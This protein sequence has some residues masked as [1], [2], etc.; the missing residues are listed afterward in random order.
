MIVTADPRGDYNA[1]SQILKYAALAKE[2]TVPRVVS[3]TS[4]I[5]PNTSATMAPHRTPSA[6]LAASTTT[7]HHHPAIESQAHIIARLT[8]ELA[9][10]RAALHDSECERQ[11][12]ES[13][14][15]AAETR[16]ERLEAEIREECWSSFEARLAQERARWRAAWEVER[17]E[18]EGFIDEKVG[19][20]VRGMAAVNVDLSGGGA[21]ASG[22][23]AEEA[24]EPRRLQQ[25]VA[26]LEREND[27]LKM[28][29]TLR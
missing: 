21:R 27:V 14:W 25:R 5:L 10:A 4:S 8:A 22:R 9:Q 15:A 23:S 17:E 1:T 13:S 28:K 2:T 12:L 29:S 19:A 11:S 24:D 20:L 3:V 18:Q 16:L 6:T 7:H 26:E